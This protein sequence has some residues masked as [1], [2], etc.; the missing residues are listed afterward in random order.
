MSTG[1]IWIMSS[2]SLFLCLTL[3]THYAGYCTA[4]ISKIENVASQGTMP[5]LKAKTKQYKPLTNF[6]A[7]A[8]C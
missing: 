2:D 6:S 1:T 7:F 4:N 3:Y 8:F 5:K